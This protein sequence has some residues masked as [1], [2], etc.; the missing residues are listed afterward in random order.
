MYN[1]T[2][3]HLHRQLHYMVLHL[4]SQHPLLYLIP[5]LEKFLDDIVA[6]DIRHQLKGVWLDLTEQ[7]LLLVTVGSLQLLLDEA[8]SMLVTTELN[9][10]IIYILLLV[11]CRHDL[12]YSR[13]LTF[14]S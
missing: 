13:R 8:R 5:V 1:S 2:P 12:A 14:N 9:Y 7:L 6:E 4:L 10:M 3:V 11:S